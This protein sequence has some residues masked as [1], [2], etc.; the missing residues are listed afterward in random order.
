MPK[1][2]KYHEARNNKILNEI[3]DC[4]KYIVNNTAFFIIITKRFEDNHISPS[5]FPSPTT[6][7]PISFTNTDKH[8]FKDIEAL[9]CDCVKVFNQYYEYSPL[10]V[11]V[12]LKELNSKPIILLTLQ[13]D[14]Y[15]IIYDFNGDIVQGIRS[16]AIPAF[17]TQNTA[18]FKEY[19]DASEA[20]KDP[21]LINY[22]DVL[23]EI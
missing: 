21:T 17:L 16:I 4:N 22:I 9:F 6:N 3:T 23:N 1:Y 11:L 15:G 18:Y 13:D 8:F 2:F 12:V 19:E 14:D 20:F 5:L 7:I 10:H